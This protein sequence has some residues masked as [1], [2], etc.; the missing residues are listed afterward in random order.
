MRVGVNSLF[1]IPREVG[2]T[3]IYVRSVLPA[4][5]DVHP[6]VEWVVFTNA[7][8]H[9]SFADY[10]R[11]PLGV[12]ATSRTQRILAEQRTLPRLAREAGIDLLYS[13]GYTAPIRKRCPQVTTIHDTQMFDFPEDFSWYARKAQKVL[14]GKGARASD[15][16]TT[17]S[18]FSRHRIHRHFGVPLDRIVVAHSAL[19]GLFAKPQPCAMEEPFL[20][21]V[22]ATYPHK[23]ATRLVNVF[24]AIADKI[25]HTLV[26]VGQPRDGEPPPHPRMKRL[27]HIPYEEL[28]GLFQHAG[29]VVFP[30]EYEGFGRPVPEAQEAGTRVIAADAACIPEIAGDGATFFDP[31][32]EEA[33]ARAIL[34]ALDESADVRQRYIDA[35]LENAKRFTWKDCARQTY[36]AFELALG[37]Q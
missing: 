6:D 25:P 22:A 5:T 19:S 18:D 30:S 10:E 37:E 2:G 3:E 7:E 1:L 36:K 28:I 12:R 35:G 21:Y 31:T 33:I 9:D 24:A 32:D 16:V 11:I 4:M 14:V 29:L 17:V 34:D 27:H 26:L 15:A 23:N 8:N 13:P 20:L